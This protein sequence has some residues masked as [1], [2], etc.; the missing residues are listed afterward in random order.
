MNLILVFYL[1]VCF[2]TGC[3]C[4]T[5]C[6]T[7]TPSVDQAGLELT[8]ILLPLP[9]EFWDK[10]YVPPCPGYSVVGWYKPLVPAFGKQRQVYKASL[11]HI[12]F[13]L[14]IYFIYLLYVST[15]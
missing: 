10:R 4:L 11:V 7:T 13:Y 1:F 12:T 6:F 9:P 14:F 5:A 2:E 15:L 8:D 3:F